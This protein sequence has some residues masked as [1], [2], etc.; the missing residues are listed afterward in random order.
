LLAVVDGNETDNRIERETMELL[1]RDV[2]PQVR[3]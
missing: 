3:H 2:L 1:M